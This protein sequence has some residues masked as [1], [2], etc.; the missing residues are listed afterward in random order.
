MRAHLS[1][2]IPSLALGMLAALLLVVSCSSV[3]QQT[4]EQRVS[5]LRAQV[6]D[7]DRQL[8]VM[9]SA[10]GEEQ[11]TLMHQYWD[12]LQKQLRYVHNLPG[13]QSRGCNDWTMQDTAITGQSGAF[14]GSRPCPTLHDDGPASGLPFPDKLSPMLFQLMM[15]QQL[16]DLSA[17]V[18]AI[19]TAPDATARLD[20][21]RQHYET[22]YRDLQTVLG[23]GWMWTAS[24]ESDLPDAESMGA[25]LF[26]QYCSQCHNA[27]PPA[28]NTPAEWTYVTERMSHIIEGQAHSGAMGVNLPSADEFQLIAQYLTM[29]GYRPTPK[30]K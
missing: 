8:V 24:K 20:L 22:R 19:E 2:L 28:L 5:A 14:W 29:H 17:Q 26:D 21:I 25:V 9:H 3:P 4:P 13:V 10:S 7:L 30:S 23:R 15:Q 27:P 11:Q 18:D 6:E 1:H 16:N 12:T